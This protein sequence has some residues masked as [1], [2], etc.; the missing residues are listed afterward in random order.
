[1]DMHRHAL[2]EGARQERARQRDRVDQKREGEHL[3][4][5][6]AGQSSVF[7]QPGLFSEVS[8]RLRLQSALRTGAYDAGSV[9]SARTAA[10][11]IATVSTSA[12]RSSC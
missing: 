1:V 11:I 10:L 3:R 9:R 8:A 12:S 7:T 2:D 5:D 6:D 4:G